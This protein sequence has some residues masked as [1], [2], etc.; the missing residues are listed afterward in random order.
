MARDP[1]LHSCHNVR[2]VAQCFQP[3]Q[4]LRNPIK[5][6]IGAGNAENTSK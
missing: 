1:E 5:G 6:N 2:N 3:D 4:E